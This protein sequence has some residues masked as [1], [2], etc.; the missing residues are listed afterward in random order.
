[1]ANEDM[2]NAAPHP[3]FTPKPWPPP[4][5]CKSTKLVPANESSDVKM[6]NDFDKAL[7]VPVP[8]EQSVAKDES[9]IKS[10]D[11]TPPASKQKAQATEKATGTAGVKAKV[12][13]RKK[14]VGGDEEIVPASDEELI[15]KLKKVKVKV[16]N[17]INFAAKKME[18]NKVKGNKYGDMLKSISSK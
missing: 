7:F 17:E 16:H 13:E 12:A 9:A 10:D 4:H 5:N 18:E 3:L 11:T 15:P 6:G 14:K 2:V 1:M 8:S